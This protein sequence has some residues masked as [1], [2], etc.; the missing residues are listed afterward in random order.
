MEG[1][2]LFKNCSIFRADGRVREGMA[3][4]VEGNRITKVAGDAELPTLPGDWEI[5]C[6]GRLLAPGLADCHTHLVGGQL[7]PQ[8]AEC[9][10]RPSAQR[11]ER[12]VRLST[13]LTAGEVEALTAHAIARGLK[14]GVTL[15]VEHL[16]AP[17]DVRGALAAQARTAE[18]LV[19]RLIHSHASFSS[20]GDGL[21]QLE[22]NVEHVQN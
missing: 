2:L 14:Q 19:A 5:A 6:R 21:N 15:R 4:V 11:L 12:L 17:G 7:Q 9:L 3:V 16:L 18:K 1:R 8:T 22:A 20:T 10:L 13:L